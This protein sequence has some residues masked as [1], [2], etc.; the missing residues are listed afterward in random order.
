M[1]AKSESITKLSAALLAA[2]REVTHPTKNKVNPRFKSYYA[3]LTSVVDTVIPVLNA[4]GLAVLQ[5]FDGDSLTTTL[6]HESG[7]WIETSVALPVERDGPQAFGSA[8][9]YLRRYT[10]QA[11][12]GVNAE[13]DDDANRAEKPQARTSAPASFDAGED[14]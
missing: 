3:D 6:V 10:L 14:W 2:Q 8:L 12:V 9:T 7:E 11:L 13:D 1:S 5:G 4:H